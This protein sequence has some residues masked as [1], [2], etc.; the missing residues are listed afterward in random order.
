M[1][2]IGFMECKRYS[3]YLSQANVISRKG[4]AGLSAGASDSWEQG[5][6]NIRTVND[7][8][9]SRWQLHTIDEFSVAEGAW[10]DWLVTDALVGLNAGRV[11]RGAGPV[12]DAI[13]AVVSLPASLAEAGVG[14]QLKK[15]YFTYFSSPWRTICHQ[16]CTLIAWATK[17]YLPSSWKGK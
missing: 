3:S 14:L 13:L 17:S 5:T 11:D 9:V 1:F 12:L 15:Y 6:C 10:G 7:R 8:P 16:T 2:H 4:H